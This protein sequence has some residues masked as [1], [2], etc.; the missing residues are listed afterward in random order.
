M[1][2]RLEAGAD[3]G[4]A[5]SETVAVA[6]AASKGR[7]N[8]LLTDGRTVAATAVGNSLVWAAVGPGLVVAS[9]PYDESPGWQH[10][11]DRS[12]LVGS[13]DGVTVIPI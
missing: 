5:L 2:E 6:E 11:P 9:E 12:L 7:F 10:V 4:A 13:L 3:L 8:F 1:S